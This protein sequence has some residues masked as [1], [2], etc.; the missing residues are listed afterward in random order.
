MQPAQ[1]EPLFTQHA[2][3]VGGEQDYWE[4]RNWSSRLVTQA[5]RSR[6]REGRQQGARE[7]GGSDRNGQGLRSRSPASPARAPPQAAGD[8]GL[9]C[10]GQ[11]PGQT[12]GKSR[13]PGCKARAGAQDSQASASPLGSSRASS[14]RCRPRPPGPG[15]TH[16][17][18]AG[19][20][21][22]EDPGVEQH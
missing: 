12:R 8:T 14:A 13:S 9:L 18:Q 16:N 15:L 20:E 1:S 10:R 21:G 6:A 22:H 2:V 5:G 19:P 7:G 11:R 3:R 17:E 4:K